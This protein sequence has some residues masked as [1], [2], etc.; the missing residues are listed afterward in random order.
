MRIDCSTIQFA[1][2]RH[3]YEETRRRE[4]LRLWVGQRPNFEGQA[5]STAGAGLTSAAD[6]SLSMTNEM[7]QVRDEVS[8][9][10]AA[11][12]A[13]RP[14][15]RPSSAPP[16][17]LELPNGRVLRLRPR[18][19][20]AP[21]PARCSAEA[22]EEAEARPEDADL[23]PELRMLR[24]I[25]EKLFGVTLRPCPR[26][27]TEGAPCTQDGARSSES[28]S[29]ADTQGEVGWG[30]EYDLMETHYESE[31]T[32]FRAEGIIRTTDGREIRF[33]F[34][35]TMSREWLQETDIHVRAG[36]AA[37][38][39]LVLNFDGSAAELSA[40]PFAF[41]LDADGEE[42]QIASLGAGSGFLALD[43]N[44]DGRIND[45]SELFGPRSG[46]GF[47]DL[48]QHDHD[49]NGWIDE[50]D[51][52]YAQLRIWQ[53]QTSGLASLTTLRERGVG[54]IY[55]GRAATLFDLRD[56]QNNALGQVVSSGVFLHEDGS[57][58]SMQQV[59]LVI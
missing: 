13:A 18:R 50:N 1:S 17:A 4:T 35:L 52:I 15:G 59:N 45:G 25:L 27:A 54:A 19:P 57:V 5:A 3:F 47:A 42:E 55:L 29:E 40:I 34:G 58:G 9:S 20:L 30:L 37:Q 36:N 16:L 26:P 51:A 23:S 12:A 2:L 21:P 24:L 56:G 6:L 28:L 46:D 8:L 22:K 44:H 31:Q 39:P 49:G 10:G 11:L 53:P 33:R 41:D 38:D 14:Q 43:L 48:A 32:A 7:V